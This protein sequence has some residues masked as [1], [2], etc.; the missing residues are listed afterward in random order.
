[1]NLK[2]TGHTGVRLGA[3]QFSHC[4][5]IGKRIELTEPIVNVTS[6]HVEPLLIATYNPGKIKEIQHFL[7]GLALP[8][9]RSGAV[10]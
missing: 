6:T 2:L 9:C 8:F 3:G 4:L 10:A 7:E 1:M 5:T